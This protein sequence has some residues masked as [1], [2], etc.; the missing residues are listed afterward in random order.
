MHCTTSFNGNQ[1]SLSVISD[2]SEKLRMALGQ[3]L[4][5]VKKRGRNYLFA[6][7]DRLSILS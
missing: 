5:E 1:T 7:D 2:R 3:V 6:A 4:R